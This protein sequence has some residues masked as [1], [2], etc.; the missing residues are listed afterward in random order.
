MNDVSDTW[1]RRPTIARAATTFHSAR[2]QLGLSGESAII[3][4]DLALL[5]EKLRQVRGAF[6]THAR[7]TVAIKANP[8]VGILREVV[9]AGFGLEAASMGEIR[10][11]EAAGCRPEDIVFDSPAKTHAEIEYA[12]RNGIFLNVDNFVELERIAALQSNPGCCVGMRINPEVGRGRIATT[13]VGGSDSRFGVPIGRKVEIVEAFHRYPW[14]TGLHV[15]IGSQ[16]FLLDRLV[17]AVKAVAALK[18][19]IEDE[20]GPGRVSYVD[21]GGGLPWQYHDE[22]IPS[23]SDYARTIRQEA[24]GVFGSDVCLVTEFG[25]AIQAGCGYALSRVEY[26]KKGPGR[27]TIVT[28]LGADFLVRAAYHPE[29]WSHDIR[30]MDFEG[31]PRSQ[32][33]VEYDIAGPLCFAGDYIAK[34]RFLPHV[35]PGD[36]L[37]IR[38][39]G[40][41]TLGMW[42]RH[43]S[44]SQ[45]AVVGCDG[46]EVR[47]LRKAERPEDIVGYWG[48]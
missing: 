16:S 21:I 47:L 7:H 29:D 23:V 19:H 43:C 2:E 32:E 9:Q 46:A 1:L 22:E 4:H 27:T 38:D 24:P 39:V 8:V 35:L 20:I 33:I 6:P 28:H 18:R 36:W 3:F 15:H 44:R 25:R 17:E 5:R 12:T 10:I 31:Q 40:A 26:I 37:L 48:G 14:L 42:S 11:A 45:P 30:V 13:S 41:Y 34:G